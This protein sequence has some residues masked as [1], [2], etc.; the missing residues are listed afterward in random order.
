MH[1]LCGVRVDYMW[2]A[3]AYVDV[4]GMDA[5]WMRYGCGLDVVQMRY[6]CVVDLVS[7][8]CVSGMYLGCTWR[9][10]GVDVAWMSHECRLD[11]VCLRHAYGM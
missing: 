11:V 3:S 10:R 1:Y 5:V 6:E 7:M 4:R 9:G 2:E 8:E